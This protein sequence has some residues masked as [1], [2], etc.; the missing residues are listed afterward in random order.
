[1]KQAICSK[2][3]IEFSNMVPDDAGEIT[4]FACDMATHSEPRGLKYTR[5]QWFSLSM[6]LR[7]RWW[8]ETNYGHGLPSPELQQLIAEALE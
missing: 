2:C 3:G 7:R 5:E 4:C 8:L 1:M 6:K